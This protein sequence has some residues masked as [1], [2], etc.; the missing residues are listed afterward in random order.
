V[1]C[2]KAKARLEKAN[3]LK[4]VK[5][6]TTPNAT[7]KIGNYVL[8][9]WKYSLQLQKLHEVNKAQ[10]KL[11][12]FTQENT[13]RPRLS[14]L[15]LT[16]IPVIWHKTIRNR[17]FPLHPFY[18]KTSLFDSDMELWERIFQINRKKTAKPDCTNCYLFSQLSTHN[19]YNNG[20]TCRTHFGLLCSFFMFNTLTAGLRYI[21]TWIS[22]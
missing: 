4:T 9:N 22:A 21:C 1:K 17:F 10:R 18:L 13:V 3:N 2:W 20:R 8:R 16:G 7:V 11:Q 14:E 15:L 12:W 5:N 19:E 6:R